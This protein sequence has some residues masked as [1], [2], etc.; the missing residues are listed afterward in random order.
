VIVV[1][2]LFGVFIVWIAGLVCVCVESV[3]RFLIKAIEYIIIVKASE[4]VT[5]TIATVSEAEEGKAI[6]F[7]SMPIVEISKKHAIIAVMKYIF[8]SLVLLNFC[9]TLTLTNMVG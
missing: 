7:N 4:A 2:V 9:H 8:C 3:F 1:G 5:V 6:K